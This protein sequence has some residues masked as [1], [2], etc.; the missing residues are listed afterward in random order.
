MKKAMGIPFICIVAF[1]YAITGVALA[2][3]SSTHK[4]V[5]PRAGKVVAKV[6]IPAGTGGFAVGEGGVWAVSDTGP[7]LT[8]IDPD[9]NAVAVV[10]S[11]RLNLVSS[12]PT[13]PPGCGEAAA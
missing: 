4:A 1:A 2:P 8:R 13:K 6:S 12:C 10:A 11:I 5:H 7:V 3:G 9:R